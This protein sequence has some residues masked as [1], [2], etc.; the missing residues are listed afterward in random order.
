MAKSKSKTILT[1]KTEFQIDF[2]LLTSL[3]MFAK[4]IDNRI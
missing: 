4:I 3:F 2:I 1:R